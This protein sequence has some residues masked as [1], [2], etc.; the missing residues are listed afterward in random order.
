MKIIQVSRSYDRKMSDGNYGSIGHFCSMTADLEEGENEQ[1][2]SKELYEACK[3]AVFA[4]IEEGRQGETEA[5][6]DYEANPEYKGA[7]RLV[8]GKYVPAPKKRWTGDPS[9]KTDK[10]PE[11]PA[12]SIENRRLAREAGVPEIHKRAE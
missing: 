10:N 11:L 9:F 12:A 4:S 7:F 3:Q 5:E 8:N 2:A 1:E 6:P